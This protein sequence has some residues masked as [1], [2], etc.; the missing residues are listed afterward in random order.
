MIGNSPGLRPFTKPSHTLL[1]K[2]SKRNTNL[3]I[4]QRSSDKNFNKDIGGNHSTSGDQPNLIPVK[5]NPRS[6]LNNLEPQTLVQ[7]TPTE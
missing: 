7:V 6:L 2:S 1:L 5:Y 3:A 4:D